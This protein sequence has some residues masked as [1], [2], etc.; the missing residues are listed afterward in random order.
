[1]ICL[2]PVLISLP[3]ILEATKGTDRLFS[4][5]SSGVV[6]LKP[7]HLFCVW[8]QLTDLHGQA[9][10]CCEG[11]PAPVGSAAESGCVGLAAYPAA[12]S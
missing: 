11:Q 7:C 8:L 9:L 5:R 4:C 6:P 3:L 12:Q 2:R 1:M 10:G